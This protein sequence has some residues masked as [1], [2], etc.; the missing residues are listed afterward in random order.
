MEVTV[1]SH[2]FERNLEQNAKQEEEQAREQEKSSG[3][4]R[5][6]NLSDLDELAGVMSEEETLVAQM[7]ADH[8]NSIDY[9]A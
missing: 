9:T 5:R 2:E 3:K 7:M 8:G 4:M 6:L 1:G